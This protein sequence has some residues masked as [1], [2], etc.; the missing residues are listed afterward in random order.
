M[1]G[2]F[3][4]LSGAATVA[5]GLAATAYFAMAPGNDPFAGCRTTAIAGGAGAIGGEFELVAHTG[6]TVTHETLYEEPT[7]MYFGFTYCPDVCP[8]DT[9]R[10]AVAIDILAEQGLSV[11][12]VFV[13][14]DPERDTPEVLAEFVPYV[15]PDMIGLTGDQAAMDQAKKAFKVYAA[16]NGEGE[17]YLYDHSTFSYLMGPDGS[18]WEFFRR[19]LTPEQLADRVACFVNA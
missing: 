10:N 9:G 8:L 13:S 15:H 11:T 1:N 5:L 6:E 12:P 2:K 7:L 4:A 19:D 14:V 16:K 18:F 17:D 3:F